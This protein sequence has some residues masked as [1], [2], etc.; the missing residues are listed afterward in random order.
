[1][2]ETSKQ[3]LCEGRVVAIT[4]GGRGIGRAEA[5]EMAH[6]G[7]HLIVNNRSPGP[8]HE[9]VDLIRAEGGTAVAHVGDVSD[10]A[11]AAALLDTALVSFGRLDV[12]VNN[13][14]IVR[15][16]MFVN[17]SEED[18]DAV[19]RVNLKGT[20]TTLSQAARYWR[21]MAKQGTPVA[22]AVIN[23]TSNAG[24]FRNTGQS[25]Y[26]AAKAGVANLTIN[27]AYELA[28]YGVTANALAPAAATDMSGHLIDPAK[29]DVDGFDPYAPENVA[30]LVA[31][32]A[33]MEAR[34]VTGRVFEV[35]GGRVAVVEPWRIGPELDLGRK[36]DAA[37]MGTAVTDLVARARGN[38]DVMGRA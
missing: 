23:T 37:E 3:R 16:R 8:A 38:V 2:T 27:A 12:L 24:L 13:A 36:W 15:D 35:K 18:W 17:L 6:H 21:R 29:R 5:I 19:V 11:V 31:W 25:N 9:V 10:M 20:Y 28:S 32:L 34:H 14:G 33:S 26:A 30:P 4:G 1:M 7:A 22:A